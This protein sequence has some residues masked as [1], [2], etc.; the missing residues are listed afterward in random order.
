MSFA[1]LT[2]PQEYAR[3]RNMITGEGAKLRHQY[4][5]ALLH[6]N[7]TPLN[8]LFSATP[9]QEEANGRYQG[10]LAVISDITELKR[11]E[12][13]LQ[14]ERALLAQR[15][16]ER[17]AELSAANA[18]L[19]RAARLKDEFLAS[20]SHELRTPLNAILGMSEILRRE[21][22]GSLNTR[23]HKYVHTIEES[24]QHL[25]NLINDILD[26]SKI[27]AGKTTLQLAPFSVAEVCQ[28]SLKLIQHS[29]SEKR[30]GI[31]FTINDKGIVLN[32]DKR[33]LKQILVNLLSNAVKFTPEGGQIGMDVVG[34]HT[35]GVVKFTIW[36]T[37]IGIAPENGAR[38]FRPFIQLDSSL[39]RQH[40]G[41]GL[42]L[43][44]VYRLTKMHG[45]SVSMESTLNQGSHFTVTLPWLDTEE[46]PSVENGP[47]ETSETVR[48]ARLKAASGTNNTRAHLSGTVVL[49]AEDNESNIET[50]TGYLRAARHQVVVVRDGN[51]VL[52]RALETRPDII[53]MDIHLPGVDGVEAIRAIRAEGTLREIPIIAVTA[54]TMQG[55]CER[56]LGAGANT[57]LNK[58]ISLEEMTRS[59]NAQL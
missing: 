24:G 12:A 47:P 7:G 25:L 39:S 23:Q 29:A 8:V 19:A 48:A 16:A 2:S 5:T 34:D 32:A 20:T 27:E 56:C 38:L 13:A 4:E 57:Y 52:E 17:T 51:E 59:I 14:E 40:E 54:L 10:T 43:A 58:P 9:L 30:I 55:D 49:L 37:G 41:T 35:Q 15:V 42:G 33:R 3:Y 11:A 18:E 53:V 36:D 22:Y 46:T 21:L 6:K 50:F 26:L 44:L 28:G 45:G 31:T 1:E